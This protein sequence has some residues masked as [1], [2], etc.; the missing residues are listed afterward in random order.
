MSKVAFCPGKIIHTNEFFVGQ[1]NGEKKLM[2]YIEAVEELEQSII[3]LRKEIESNKDSKF[4]KFEV[5]SEFKVEKNVEKNFEKNVINNNNNNKELKSKSKSKESTS[6]STHIN[7]NINQ[8]MKSK[9]TK[10]EKEENKE[11]KEDYVVP[12]EIRETYDSIG[13]VIDTQVVDLSSQF[14]TTQSLLSELGK[15]ESK[16]SF[17]EM[18]KELED[19]LNFPAQSN[20]KNVFE[21]VSY[22]LFSFFFLLFCF[23]LFSFLLFYF[24]LIL[25]FIFPFP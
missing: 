5:K 2:S 16:V 8:T 25:Y 14:S 3:C 18:Y 11:T 20:G 1:E 12:V 7:T 22:F 9:S 24:V 13:N 23:V 10:L 21:D 17:D 4:D 19:R 15:G 6:K